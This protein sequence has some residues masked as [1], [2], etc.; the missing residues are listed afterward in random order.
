MQ[1][2]TKKS[3]LQQLRPPGTFPRH[4]KAA[5]T[6]KLP[7][8]YPLNN[9]NHT[10]SHRVIQLAAFIVWMLINGDMSQR[11]TQSDKCPVAI[12]SCSDPT[13]PSPP[14]LPLIN[15]LLSTLLLTYKTY[16]K[17]EN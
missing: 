15:I 2:R 13:Q 3:W 9:D 17:P 14:S 8:A 6:P 7:W 4:V 12:Y 11:R 16:G 10:L 5:T 1:T